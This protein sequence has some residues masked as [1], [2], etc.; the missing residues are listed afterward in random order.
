MEKNQKERKYA[1]GVNAHTPVVISKGK[2]FPS[3][4]NTAHL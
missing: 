4:V 1:R 3:D 2:C